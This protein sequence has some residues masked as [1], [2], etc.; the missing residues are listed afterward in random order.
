MVFWPA[1][2]I[3]LD[4][5]AGLYVR[6]TPLPRKVLIFPG[7]KVTLCA[8][9]MTLIPL[10]PHKFPVVLACLF[11]TAVVMTVP[12]HA[13]TADSLSITVTKNGD[14]TATFTYTLEGVIENAIPESVLQEQLVKG[15]ATSS[16]PPQVTSFDKS[17]ATLVLKNFAVTNAVPTGTEY[18]TAPMDFKNAQI[19]LENSAVSTV[20]SADFSPKT[21]TVTFPDGY[22]KELT[23][24][25]VLPSIKH[26]VVDPAKAAAAV[27]PA[28]STGALRVSAVP[29]NARVS[30]DSSYAGEGTETFP[31][32]APGHHTI[33]LDADGYLSYTTTVTIT[34]GN[35]STIF[36]TLDPVP[37]TTRK[38][39]MPAADAAA[40][41]LIS[42]GCVALFSRRR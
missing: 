20:I 40:M 7:T 1:P 27:T 25:S 17:G 35:T 33:K 5:R 34:A 18:Q 36:A 31:G 4:T 9:N 23:D 19:A 38:A 41:A 37:P 32:L 29:E 6:G 10:F 12:A 26:T 42:F 15:L 8:G 3:N 21:I 22:A 28:A 16:D 14:A 24:S 13:F 39:G 30:V 2:Y 11:A